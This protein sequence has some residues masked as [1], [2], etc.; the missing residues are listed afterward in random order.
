[1]RQIFVFTAGD[2]DARSHL[3]DSILNPVPFALLRDALG[4]EDAEYFE[5][6]MPGQQGFYAWGAVPGPR[7]EPTWQEMQA[8]D[9]VLT[10][11]DNRY[12]FVSTVLGKF[13]HKELATR[14]WGTTT[15]GKTWEYMYLLSKPEPVN[16]H[17]QDDSVVGYLSKSYFGYTRIANKKVQAIVD[18]FG[19]LDA[20]V[21]KVF[22][23]SLPPTPG[24][25]AL[26]AA[27]KEAETTLAFDPA[28]LVDGRNKVLLEVV[29][30][31]G[32]PQFRAKLIEA[33]GGR[34]A[35]TGCDVEAVLEA[36]HISPYRGAET[37]LVQNGLLLRADIHTLFDLGRLKIATDL[38]VKLH[39]NLQGTIYSEFDGR[40]IRVPADASKAPSEKALL[41]KFGQG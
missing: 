4:D 32:Q 14:I 3:N 24:D 27:R 7:N 37:N 28:N 16:V 41:Q 38:T 18:G 5:S 9:L 25:V 19:S 17:I 36:A 40:Q 8:G 33:Y 39:E 26:E 20:F 22:K 23:K 13:N 30:R 10:V 1:M 2:K 12:R 31:Q 35:V 34:C 29:R 11:Y 6:L 21:D 15:D